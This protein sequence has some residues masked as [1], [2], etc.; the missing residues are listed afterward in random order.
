MSERELGLDSHFIPR[1]S[2]V[3]LI[4]PDNQ[5]SSTEL[6]PLPEAEREKIKETAREGRLQIMQ[7]WIAKLARSIEDKIPEDIR[8]PVRTVVSNNLNDLGPIGTF[9]QTQEAIKG[10]TWDG[11][12]LTPVGRLNHVVVQGLFMYAW[13]QGL[14]GDFE[15]SGAAYAASWAFDIVQYYP[16]TISGL[17]SLAEKYGKPGVTEK[18]SKLKSVLDKSI[19]SKAFFE[20][21]SS[22]IKNSY[23]SV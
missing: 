12:K 1:E 18:L 21:P 19:L 17:I 7:D 10:V 16:N 11:K 8:K 6:P 5:A 22:S 13:Q 2:E 3:Q 4:V 23:E 9:K 15:T 20:E 14:Q